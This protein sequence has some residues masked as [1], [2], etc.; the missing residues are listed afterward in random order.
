MPG[1]PC[2]SLS[3]LSAATSLIAPSAGSREA[4]RCP[5][6]SASARSSCSGV[7]ARCRSRILPIC[8]FSLIPIFDYPR[9][10][11]QSRR[12]KPNSVLSSGGGSP[13]SQLFRGPVGKIASFDRLPRSCHQTTVEVEVVLAEQAQA[14]DLALQV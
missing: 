5:F 6:C 7:S 9:D 12:K 11:R 2:C 8:F 13:I 14:Q 3:A 1:I 10:P 4:R